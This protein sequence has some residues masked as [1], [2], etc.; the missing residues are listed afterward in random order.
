MMWKESNKVKIQTYSSNHIDSIIHLENDNTIR[1]TG[2]YGNADPNKRKIS[3]GQSIKKKWII[4]GDFN[5]ILDNAEK[6][7]GRRKPSAL[8]EDFCGVVDELLMVDLKTDN[9]KSTVLVKERLGHFLMSANGVTSFPF[10]ETKS[11][12]DHDVIILDTEVLNTM[13]AGLKMRKQKKLSKKL[14]RKVSKDIMGKI[15]RVGKELGGWQYKIGSTYAGDKL[16]AMRL[17]H[18]NLL[19][20]EEKYWAHRSRVN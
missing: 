17:K 18:G 13:S 8:M 7:G 9:R 16:K 3:V 19:D 1:F 5:A 14:G 12:S 11:I 10:M 20:K 6:E 15:E 2:F 4:G